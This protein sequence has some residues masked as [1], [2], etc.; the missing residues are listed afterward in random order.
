MGLLGNNLGTKPVEFC[1]RAGE[2]ALETQVLRW[3]GLILGARDPRFELASP[4]LII[5]SA[6]RRSMQQ[7]QTERDN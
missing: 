6:L 7:L 4:C 2:G 1:S 3:V 5:L